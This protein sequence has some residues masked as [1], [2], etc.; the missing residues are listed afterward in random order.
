V[1]VSLSGTDHV[2]DID[3]QLDA[4]DEILSKLLLSINENIPPD[5]PT[6]EADLSDFTQIKKVCEQ[7][8]LLLSNDDGEAED[9]FNEHQQLLSSA[10]PDDIDALKHA[11]AA[12]DY[13]KA[14]KLICDALGKKEVT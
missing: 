6:L 7:L 1:S 13:K 14:M 10:F 11:I 4:L 2:P 12:V 5:H 8:N 3:V 9:L